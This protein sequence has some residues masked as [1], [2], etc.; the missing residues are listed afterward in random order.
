[1]EIKVPAKIIL[2]GEHSVVYPGN[3]AI[4]TT[5]NLFATFNSSVNN[6]ER[7]KIVFPQF[8]GEVEIKLPNAITHYKKAQGLR[9]SYLQTN[10]IDELSLFVNDGM[11][12]FK[13]LIGLISNKYPI[14][15]FLTIKIDSDI[16]IGSGL[17]S[18][19]V[20]AI[21]IIKSVLIHNEIQFSDEELFDLSKEMEDFQHGKSSGADPAC[22]ISEGLILY[23][24]KENGERK[25]SKIEVP[26]KI[27]DGLNLV[28]TGKPKETTG[29]MVNLVS[30]NNNKSDIFKKIQDLIKDLV[31]NDFHNFYNA[32]NKNGRLLEELGIVNSKTLKFLEGIREQGGYCKIS[33]A[34]GVSEDG[35]G[36]SLIFNINKDSLQNQVKLNSFNIFDL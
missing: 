27:L 12:F 16:P 29:E 25:F 5:I 28:F 7:F 36:I 13:I 18:S 31:D 30:N 24:H 35:S 11:N 9:D 8:R 2:L 21:G 19:A 14:K 22:I 34:G 4:L 20:I 10:K 23:E 6:T 17:G 3:S 26:N 33:G 15:K 1:M 32:I